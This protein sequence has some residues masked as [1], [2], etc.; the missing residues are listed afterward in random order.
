MCGLEMYDLKSITKYN[1]NKK[2]DSSVSKMTD[3][4]LNNLISIPCSGIIIFLINSTS[5][6]MSH[7]A[8]PTKLQISSL[9]STLN[10]I[11]GRKEMPL[12]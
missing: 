1:T 2:Q 7:K 9:C 5:R 8:S 3:Y 12:L 6:K 4:R 11:S 10:I